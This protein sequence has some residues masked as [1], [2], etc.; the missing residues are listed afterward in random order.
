MT[1]L[2]NEF[3]WKNSVRFQSIIIAVILFL[4][5]LPY[6]AFSLINNILIFP[7]FGEDQTHYLSRLSGVWQGYGP[8]FALTSFSQNELLIID[9]F[10]SVFERIFFSV[11]DLFNG[12]RAFFIIYLCLFI[13]GCS[14]LLAWT[15]VSLFIYVLKPLEPKSFVLIAS[16]VFFLFVS[17]IIS[18]Q[19]IKTFHTPESIRFPVPLIHFIIIT[20]L[21]K[22]CISNTEKRLTYAVLVGFSSYIYFYT[23]ILCLLI[24]FFFEVDKVIS[25]RRY[26]ES[27]RNLFLCLLISAPTIFALLEHELDFSEMN[28]IIAFAFALEDSRQPEWSSSM[29]ILLV[30]MILSIFLNQKTEKFASFCRLNLIVF[31]VSVICYNQQVITGKV[32]QIGHFHWYFIYPFAITFGFL[33]VLFLLKFIHTRLLDATVI[34]VAIFTFIASV[35]TAVNSYSGLRSSDVERTVKAYKSLESKLALDRSRILVFDESLGRALAANPGPRS[36]WHP[37][38]IHYQQDVQDVYNINATIWVIKNRDSAVNINRIFQTCKNRMG[39]DCYSFF[40]LFG[41]SSKL[42][43]S[44]FKLA[45]Q[46]GMMDERNISYVSRSRLKEASIKI[47][48]GLMTDWLSE[49]N[50]NFVLFS[51]EE[52]EDLKSFPWFNRQ[53]CRPLNADFFL[54]SLPELLESLVKFEESPKKP[55]R[56]I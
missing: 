39:I 42:N 25:L 36:A 32:L 53:L 51:K 19:G 44:D 11:G 24:L 47:S 40:S 15:A 23:W 14:A 37:F 54:C 38:G 30:S 3:K 6:L 43:R 49:N 27:I 4:P 52:I 48:E 22:G 21:L 45:W 35:S 31:L 33:W 18:T 7:T 16:V 26:I 28:R 50:L 10:N 12:S 41:S 9:G 34:S 1:S 13:L 56:K 46:G 17:F 29:S 8:A 2:I 20:Y 5:W 55:L